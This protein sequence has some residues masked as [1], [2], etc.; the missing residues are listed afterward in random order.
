MKTSVKLLLLTVAILQFG[1][2]SAQPQRLTKE[3][4]AKRETEQAKDQLALSD[5][6]VVKYGKIALKYAGLKAD[7]WQNRPTD[8]E[9][10]RKKM[11][12][13]DEKQKE[14]VKKIVTTD[15]FTK[16]EKI[17]EERRSRRPPAARE[18]GNGNVPPPP[19]SN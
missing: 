15:Q 7:I 2:L 5:S 9:E 18:G 13:L 17:L 10:V 1:I 19:P 3:E 8:R 16:Y 6:Q 11:N 4:M 14:E 12:E